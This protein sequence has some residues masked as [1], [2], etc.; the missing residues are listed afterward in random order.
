MF[1]D[2]YVRVELSDLWTVDA[3]ATCWTKKWAPAW[4]VKADLGNSPLG[5]QRGR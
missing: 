4:W 2:N 3:K 5:S 1:L